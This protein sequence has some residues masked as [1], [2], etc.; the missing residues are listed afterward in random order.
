MA[1]LAVATTVHTRRTPERI[2]STLATG[3]FGGALLGAAARAWMRLIG[4]NPEFSWNGTMFIVLGFTI[5]GLTQSI[6]AVVRRRAARRWPVMAARTI[7][8][9]GML[10]LFVAAGAIM[11]PTVVGGGLARWREE[12]PRPARLLLLLVAMGPVAFVGSDLVGTF[13]WSLQ[14][15]A[16]FV[17][18]LAVYGVI[19]GATRFTFTRP[20]EVVGHRSGCEWRSPSQS[21]S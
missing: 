12:F 5:F 8:A 7:G 16:G 17:V 14:A 15:V 21:E 19:V 13:G 3:L 2:V 6:V 10:P 9:L 1:D 20:R 4:D 11:F 18:M